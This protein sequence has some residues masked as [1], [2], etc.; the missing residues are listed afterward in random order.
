MAA[1]YCPVWMIPLR[2]SITFRSWGFE[3]V[4]M[5]SAR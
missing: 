4:F 1:A 3:A 2:S 5:A